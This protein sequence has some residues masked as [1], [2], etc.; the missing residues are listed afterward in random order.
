[1]TPPKDR[2]RL[3][4]WLGAELHLWFISYST[5]LPL[6][7]VLLLGLL[8]LRIQISVRVRLVVKLHVVDGGLAAGGALPTHAAVYDLLDRL[9]VVFRLGLLRLGLVVLSL[10]YIILICT[11][12]G[13][14]FVTANS[15]NFDQL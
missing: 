9:G 8:L 7:E 5:Y 3:E 11:V 12:L 14:F 10:D 2:G 1:M 4:K 6:D 15:V 13:V